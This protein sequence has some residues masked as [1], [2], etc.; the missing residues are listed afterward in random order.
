MMEEIPQVLSEK[1]RFELLENQLR[2]H[3]ANSGSQNLQ[4]EGLNP[5]FG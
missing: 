5:L 3:F 1:G 2:L 4:C